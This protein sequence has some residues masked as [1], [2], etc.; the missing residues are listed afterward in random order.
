MKKLLLVFVP[1]VLLLTSCLNNDTPTQEPDEVVFYD[2][3]ILMHN[4]GRSIETILNKLIKTYEE[5]GEMTGV[6]VDENN[7]VVIFTANLD[8]I[9]ETND[10]YKAYGG[11]LVARLDGA[12]SAL[13][14]ATAKNIDVNDLKYAVE[15]YSYVFGGT[16]SITDEDS[17]SQNIRFSDFSMS[18][19]NS[20]T[21]LW[22]LSYSYLESY[23]PE[24]KTASWSEGLGL[25]SIT[26]YGSFSVAIL[27]D[28]VKNED[29]KFVS[30]GCY[31][32][33]VQYIGNEAPFTA[34]YGTGGDVGTITITCTDGTFREYKQSY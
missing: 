2:N 15:G 28:I 7:G 17:N 3:F 33:R 27:E 12:T 21:I 31:Q 5:A 8:R 25:G 6:T 10:T 20:S 26:K 32:F 9:K 19:A 34:R 1:A 30:G 22:S 29:L 11:T 13:S 16:I 14:E 4:H 18:F 24:T 23:T